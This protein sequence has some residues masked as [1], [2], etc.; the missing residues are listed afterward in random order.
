[1]RCFTMKHTGRSVDAYPHF[2]SGVV[3]ADFDFRYKEGKIAAV[4]MEE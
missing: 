2:F 1:M 4:V 3:M